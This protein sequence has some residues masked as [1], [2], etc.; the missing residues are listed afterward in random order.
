ME[1]CNYSGIILLACR[2]SFLSFLYSAG[3]KQMLLSVICECVRVCMEKIK[4]LKV[5]HQ[6]C[7]VGLACT[8]LG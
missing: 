3:K 8:C 5:A 6:T 1:I 2:L 4:L 7:P